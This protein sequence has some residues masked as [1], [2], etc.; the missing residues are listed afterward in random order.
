MNAVRMVLAIAWSVFWICAATL[1]LLA[2]WSQ[3]TAL[4]VANRWWAPGVL[5]LTGLHLEM[6]PLP[7]VD[8]KRPHIF[9]MNHQS[10]LDIPCAFYAIPATLRFV[11]KHSIQYIPFLGWYVWMTG[12][13]FVDRS[14]RERAIKSL[15]RAGAKI[16]AGA[17]IIAFPEGTRSRDGLLLPFKKGPFMVALEAQVPIVPV[18]I[19]GSGKVLPKGRF[20]AR[21]GHVRLKVGDP[22]PTEGLGPQD[23]DRLMETVRQS[24]SRLNCEIG[25]RGG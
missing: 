6:D 17:N 5:K 25:G 4:L 10:Q 1:V 23:R 19:E 24:L 13:I 16:R 15:S 2:T 12:M 22:I 20:A 8:W 7:N 11:A 9:M 18:A 3:E 21:P 14:N